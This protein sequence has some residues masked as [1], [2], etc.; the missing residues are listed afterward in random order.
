M[1]AASVVMDHYRFKWQALVSAP[2]LPWPS[3][4]PTPAE[5]AEFR[6]LLE[7]A[8]EYDRRTRQPDCEMAG[9]REAVRKLAESLGVDVDFV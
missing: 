1:C 6:S 3:V 9:K 8:R 4:P 5:V 2:P 7:R